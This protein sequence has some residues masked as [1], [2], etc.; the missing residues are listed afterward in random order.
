MDILGQRVIVLNSYEMACELL[1]KRSTTFSGRPRL[2]M[3]ELCVASIIIT[4]NS[5]D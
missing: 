1:D 2:V 3:S 4:S 5:F